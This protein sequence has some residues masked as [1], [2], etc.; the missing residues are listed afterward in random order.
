MIKMKIII[1]LSFV[2]FRLLGFTIS[3]FEYSSYDQNKLKVGF[4]QQA[5]PISDVTSI[6]GFAGERIRKNRENYLKTFPIDEYLEFIIQR[7][8]KDWTW[9]KAEQHGK[10]IESSILSSA[11]SKDDTLRKKVAEVFTRLIASQDTEGYLGATSPKVRTS[12]KPLRGMDAYELYFV[13]HALL[14]AYEQWNDPRDLAAAKKLGDYFLKYIGPGK[15]EFWP[16]DLRYPENQNKKLAGHSAIAGHSVHYC[17]E[18]TLLIDPMLRLYQLSG[19]KQYLDWSKWVISNIDK[20]SGWDAFSKLDL[21]AAGIM[22]VNEVQ[23]YVHSHTFQMNFLG[24]L[25]MY[26]ITGDTTYLYKVKGVWNDVA[27]RQMYITGGVSV[28]EHYE[29]G[30]VKPL[31]GRVVETCATMSWMQLTQY[32]L[33]LTSNTKYADAMEKLLW[34]HVFAAQSFDG[35]CNRYHT[36]PNGYKPEGIYR[37]PDCCTASGHRI[38]S[39][40]PTYIYSTGKNAIYV[41]QF[42]Q[43]SANFAKSLGKAVSIQQNTLYPEKEAIQIVVKTQKNEN[44]TIYLR[45]PSWCKSP[46]VKVNG[47]IIE[48][49]KPGSYAQLTRLWKNSDKIDMI[50]PMQV[51]W[52]KLD[53]FSKNVMTKLSGGEEMYKE[54][55]DTN[56]PY[57]LMRGPV[58]YVLDN[59]WWDKNDPDFPKNVVTDVKFV[60]KDNPHYPEVE[61]HHPNILGPVF[62][63]P[64]KLSDNKVKTVKMLPFSNIGI[65]YLDPNNRP[66]KNSKA[67][68]YAIFCEG[69]KE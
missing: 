52:V 25:R 15:N 12:E 34:N 23:P 24:F 35:D 8:H 36:A 47:Q 57:S 67:N 49:I 19:D 2:F 16:G 60:I 26:Q 4:V 37:N 54:L 50:L 56:A 39:L 64:V 21:V 42:V 61:L 53:H 38:I 41:N 68:S 43:S 29:Q 13:Q 58:V 30:Y 55:E 48:N 66:D 65:W 7:T 1:V 5:I 44:F 62:E 46:T 69:I 14:T 63:V 31:T 22:G 6:G 3:G 59:I 40:L 10:W 18:G 32:L 45:I 9:V 27:K 17:W 11:Q 28:G 33:E 51:V 20:W